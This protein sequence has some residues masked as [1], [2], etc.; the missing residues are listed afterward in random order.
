MTRSVSVSHL[1]VIMSM[2]R[3]RL[4]LPKLGSPP[5]TIL[6]YLGERF[7]HIPEDVW[8][9]RMARGRVTQNAGTA[10]TADTPYQHGLTIYYFK[11][12]PAEPE[13][14]VS[15]A[16][17]FRDSEILVV[18][19]PHGMR[20][21]PSGDHVERALLSRLQR[22][23]GL[24]SLVPLH[25]LDQDTAGLVLFSVN[26]QTRA[27]YHALFDKR[28][29][30]RRY[31]AIAR[32]GGSPSQKQWII[33]NRLE[34]GD[35]WY[36]QQI[37]QGRPNAVTKIEWIRAIEGLAVFHLHPR[38]G[39][40]HQLRVHMASI[41]F[42]ILGDVLYPQQREPQSFDPPLQLLA[43]E[44]RFTDPVTGDAHVFTTSQELAS[45]AGRFQR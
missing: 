42:P 22:S 29:V 39:R 21:T 34:R 1:C 4:Y 31:I 15:E 20:V 26:P 25:R 35:P 30:E 43:Y 45:C 19:K 18:D 13:S 40:K 7:P 6:K 5:A 9:D 24:S 33:E 27:R 44:L 28:A 23:T 32:A 38:T 12:Q 36:R 11:E 16:V 41:G 2:M 8:R 10:I 14:M 37:V 17:L 3:S